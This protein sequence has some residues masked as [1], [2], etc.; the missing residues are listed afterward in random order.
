VNNVVEMPRSEDPLEK[1][2]AEQRAAVLHGDGPLLVVAGAGTGKTRVITERI[3]YLL[4]TQPELTG[5]NI[6]GLTFTEKAAAEMTHRV[7]KAVGERARNL[8]LSTFHSFCYAIL[9]E[10][11]PALRMLDKYDHWILLRRNIRKLELGVF[12]QLAEPGRF[13]T[14]FVDFFSRCQDELVTPEDYA[15]HVA[16]V[17]KQY[18][19]EKDALDAAARAAREAEVRKLGE[20]ARVY[21]ISEEL[22]RAQSLLTYGSSLLQA[23]EQLRSNR[24]LLDLLRDRYHYILVDEFQD[25]NIAQLEMLWLLAGERRNIFAVGDD[26]QA[27]YRFRGASFGSFQIFA[28]RFL[29]QKI[30]PEKPPPELVVLDQ[31]YRS[32][33]RILRVSGQV[34][35]QN[36]DRIFPR[37]QLVTKHAPG[38]KIAVVEFGS[39]PEEAAWIAQEIE[40]MHAAGH[41][42]GEFAV[43]YRMHVHRDLLVEALMRRQIPF[44]IRKLSILQNRLVRDILA[45]L[46]LVVTPG[47]DVACA[48]VLAAPAWGLGPQDLARLCERTR[49][50]RGISLWEALGQ[51]QGE[52]PFAHAHKNI[53][54]LVAWIG[55][56]Q[57]RARQVTATEFLEELIAELGLV[58]V[59]DDPDRP[60]LKRLQDY[61]REWQ[62]KSATRELR[63]FIE[64][65]D[66]FEEAGGEIT[67]EDE[68]ERDAVQLMTVHAA[69]GL[70]FEH[71]FVIRLAQGAFPARP[72]DP[73]LEF[74]AELMKEE[75]PKGDFHIQEERRLFYVAMTRAKR[76]LTLTSVI[77]KR[78]KASAFLDDVL[79]PGS[80]RSD[81]VQFAPKVTLPPAQEAADPAAAEQLF[82]P[83][84][85]TARAYSRIGA[86][87]RTYRPPVFEPLQLSAT[88]VDGYKSCPLKFLLGHQWGLRGGPHAAMTFGSVMHTTIKLLVQELAKRRRVPFDEVENIYNREWHSAGFLDDYQEEEYR[89]EG[90]EQLRA[91]HASYSELLPDV[92]H[93]EKFFELSLA[94]NIVV[95][96]RMDQVNRLAGD[97]VEIVDYK[98]G[99][100]KQEGAAKKSLQL[101]LYALATREVLER[102]PVRLTFYNL[103][104]NTSVTVTHDEKQL[105]RAREE[106]QE[107]ADD[108]RAGNFP[109]K[110]G[111]FCRNC[112]YISVCPE[113]EHP[114]T[115]RPART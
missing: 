4:A 59:E 5:E 30:D 26:D 32:T 6:L 63:E 66:F 99:K 8:T 103:T 96:G 24:A 98:T 55:E 36:A 73:V 64:Y 75:L 53:G 93:Q 58:L 40:R 38:E 109:A 14:D 61:V 1:L 47:D 102:E 51:A 13:L 15:A 60:Y 107:V 25:T 77:N 48:R 17:A 10:Q 62:V 44:V 80:V 108:V 9:R 81:V 79:Q 94:G 65:L 90:L 105:N 41:H 72:R 22:I 85:P 68:P 35:A 20:V 97:E 11:N 57:R 56:L 115:I 78:S 69:K 37:K 91:F 49:K 101:S 18:E 84:D 43:L 74:P 113:H 52:P 83:A 28:Q 12:R 46:R 54:K 70:E 100:P 7:I 19:Q 87:A 42:W 92:L 112:E 88:A 23:V 45:Y 114:V 34:I 71:V 67:L 82:G 110:P 33:Q 111:F 95:H 21:R 89:K 86:W 16:R 50:G 2:N 31:N 27:I 104:T 76:R 3:R 106:V 39:A 29:G